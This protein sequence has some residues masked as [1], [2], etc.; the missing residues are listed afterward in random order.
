MTLQ[1]METQGL[2]R[3]GYGPLLF[4]LMV[5]R[6]RTLLRI[7]YHKRVP[8]WVQDRAL[9]SFDKIERISTCA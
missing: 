7:A 8:R 5:F 6:Q 1:H 4:K 9:A 2:R 3:R